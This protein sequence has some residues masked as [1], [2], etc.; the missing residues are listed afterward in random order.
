[1]RPRSSQY[2]LYLL[3]TRRPKF[4]DLVVNRRIEGHIANGNHLEGLSS[5]NCSRAKYDAS[6]RVNIE[7]VM[8]SA[9]AQ[10]A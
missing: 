9:R 2:W 4:E 8:I 5:V 1:M 6:L 10:L 7:D 3:I